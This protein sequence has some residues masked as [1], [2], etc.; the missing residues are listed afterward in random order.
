MLR[1]NVDLLKIIQLGVTLSDKDG[2]MPPGTCT[3]QFNFSFNMQYAC[4]IIHVPLLINSALV[5][6]RAR[7]TR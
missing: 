1:V 5:R 6:I 4:F 3:W 2:N 7:R